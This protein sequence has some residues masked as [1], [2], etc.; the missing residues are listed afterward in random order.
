MTRR[1]GEVRSTLIADLTCRRYEYHFGVRSQTAFFHLIWMQS[2]DYVFHISLVVFSFRRNTAIVLFSN[3]SRFLV[4][5][6]V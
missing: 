1:R 5:I 3:E 6:E 4:I 2:W